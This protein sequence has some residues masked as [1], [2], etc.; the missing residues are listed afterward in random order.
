MKFTHTA[1]CHLG[2]HRDPKLRVLI[3][4]AFSRMITDSIQKRVD[5]VLIAGDLFNTAIPGIETLKFTVS[6]L[7]KLREAGIRVYAIPG[8]HD[9]S[10]SGKTMLD[11][12]ERAGL[13]VNVW[14]Q[15]DNNLI[16]TVDKTG[17]H[18]A[19]ILGR[20]GMLEKEQYENLAIPEV[21]GE[22]IFLFHTAITEIV[23]N[24]IMQSRPLNT[25]PPGFD[26]YAGGHVHIV[27]DY[28]EKGYPHVVYPGPLFPNS[29]SE[30]EEL[31]HGGYFLYDGT[32]T[33]KD[34]KLKE[35]VTINFSADGMA[36]QEAGERL[37]REL[38]DVTNKIV[39]LRVTGV[40]SS[41]SVHDLN[42]RSITQQLTE[43]GAYTI[44]RNTTKLT[45]KEFVAQEVR[46][47]PHDVERALLEEHKAQLSLKG[48]DGA[49][50]AQKL[51][52]LLSRE[53]K[54][55]EKQY[56]YKDSIVQEALK[57]IDSR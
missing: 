11:V 40:L 12:L 30:L 56:E 33:R 28:T 52:H 41:G 10:P 49:Q 43:K 36:G 27:Q 7:S 32:L 29:F 47:E 19:G 3:E 31:Q 25:L 44:L 55:G 37:V 6:E 22:K 17:V 51:L 23:Q 1:D 46:H 8:S 20:R 34:L 42:L 9:Y 14:Q 15:E 57:I 13:L 2:G 50:L 35:V 5:F 39:L 24:E 4:E 53:P 16:F 21:T 45:T 38:P 48:K 18:L 26:Y 54:E